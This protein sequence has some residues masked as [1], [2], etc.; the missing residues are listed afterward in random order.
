MIT[1]PVCLATFSDDF[2]AYMELVQQ[3]IPIHP[4]F[5]VFIG[6]LGLVGAA[7]FIWAAFFRKR[8]SPRYHYPHRSSSP[9]RSESSGLG[10]FRRKHR[11]HRRRSRPRNPTLAEA[12]GLPPVRGGSDHP[13][14]QP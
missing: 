6:A 4:S 9:S 1:A 10:L 5:F 13:Q 8:R 12:G 14:P 3:S 7:V 11:R 2:N